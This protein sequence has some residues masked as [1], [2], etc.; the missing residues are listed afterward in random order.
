M[1]TRREKKKVTDTKTV[2][3]DMK[4][5]LDTALR[6]SRMLAKKVG[7]V[8]RKNALLTHKPEDEFWGEE[9]GRR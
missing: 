9:A 4:R 8:E 6:D 7:D 5:R 3:D 1:L 2:H